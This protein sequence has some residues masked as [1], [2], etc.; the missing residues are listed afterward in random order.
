ME[1]RVQ[2][3]SEVDL[4]VAS[5]VASEVVVEPQEVGNSFYFLRINKLIGTPPKSNSDRIL[6][7]KK[8]L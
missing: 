6:F 2:A 4:V 8:R 7:S 1:D 3:A 5:E